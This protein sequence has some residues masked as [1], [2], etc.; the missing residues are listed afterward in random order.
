MTERG[1]KIPLDSA[2][3]M[4]GNLVIERRDGQEIAVAYDPAKHYAGVRR[5]KSHFSTC[6]DAGEHRRSR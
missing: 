1:R 2:P 6:P 3:A 5:Y 4:D